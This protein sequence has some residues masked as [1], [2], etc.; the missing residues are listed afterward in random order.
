MDYRHVADKYDRRYDEIPYDGIEHVLVSFIGSNSAHKVL[1]VGCGTGH[2][3]AFLESHG[4]SVSGMDPSPQMLQKARTHV[5]SGDLK[6]GYAEKIPWE[7]DTFD[8]LFCINAV[9]H[10]EEKSQF[11][12]EAFRVLQPGGGLLIIGLDPH[13]ARDQWFVYDYFDGV[14]EHDLNRYLS[15]TALERLM[16]V[17][18]FSE[19][20]TTEAQHMAKHFPA[21]KAIEDGLLDK[22]IVSQLGILPQAD[23]DRGLQRIWKDIADAEARGEQAVLVV[24]LWLYAMMGWKR[25]QVICNK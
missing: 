21:H 4:Y 17:A 8:Q 12:S 14:L 22:T 23:F 6:L 16:Q 13:K 15:T 9:H 20:H 11:V 10:F 1:E 25:S 19:C 24:D 18:G 3:L 7:N 2:W 5:M